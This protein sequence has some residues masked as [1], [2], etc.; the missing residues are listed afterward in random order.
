MKIRLLLAVGALA[1][2]SLSACQS[3]TP[4]TR[5][6][7]NQAIF[8]SLPADQQTLVSQGRICEG[9]GPDAVFLAWGRPDN[10]PFTGQKDGKSVVRWEYTTMEPVMVMNNWA[11]LY[12]GPYG[13]YDPYYYNQASTAYVPRKAAFVEFVNGKVS[14]WEARTAR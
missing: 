4:A 5:I 12:R 3:A 2:L 13:I 8:R 11:P 6:A 1:A 7:Q 10:P 14:S 9:M